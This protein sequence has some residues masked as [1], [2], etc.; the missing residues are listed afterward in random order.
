MASKDRSDRRG[1]KRPGPGWRGNLVRMRERDDNYRQ[2]VWRRRFYVVFALTLLIGAVQGGCRI[3]LREKPV[4]TIAYRPSI[5][6]LPLFVALEKGFL[7]EAALNVDVVEFTDPTEALAL[8]RKGSLDIAAG[9]PLVTAWEE[10]LENPGTLKMYYVASI[11]GDRTSDAILAPEDSTLKELFGLVGRKLG[12]LQGRTN[13][14]FARLLLDAE[15]GSDAA[16]KVKLVE[17]PAD[18]QFREMK[19]KRVDALLTFEPWVTLGVEKSGARVL[20][21]NPVATFL[22]DPMPTDVGVVR[23]SFAAERRK[24]MNRYVDALDKAI[25]WI[26]KN[27]KE[28]R[29]IARKRL[30]LKHGEANRMALCEYQTLKET[31]KKDN[32]AQLQKLADLLAGKHGIDRPVGAAGMI[33]RPR[34][35][36]P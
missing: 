24:E 7:K 9:F 13:M 10:E 29:D 15:L 36:Q 21:A 17:L 18:Q 4:V 5:R 25:K 8:L 20:V 23:A 14:A 1:N 16:A 33:L 30:E 32:L 26:R 31:R 34:E 22:M 3:L 12:V 28:A 19:A 2:Y 11:R 35:E 27:D 6:S